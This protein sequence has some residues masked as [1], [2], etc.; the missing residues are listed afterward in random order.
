MSDGTCC[1][2]TVCPTGC[3]YTSIQTAIDAA[4]TGDT[5]NVSPNTGG[6]LEALTIDKPVKII[7]KKSLNGPDAW[8]VGTAGNSSGPVLK[9]L[10][11]YPE[12]ISFQSNNIELKGFEID[13]Q[14]GAL[15]GGTLMGST[16]MGTTISNLNIQYCTVKMDS[17]TKGLNVDY[18]NTP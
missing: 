1:D 12:M 14:G 15:A 5:I 6:Y 4:A 2:I 9:Y 17:G 10:A 13:V 8:T 18:G 3:D 11:G 16:P 7:G